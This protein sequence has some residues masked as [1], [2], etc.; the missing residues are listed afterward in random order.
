MLTTLNV[1]HIESLNDVVERITGVKVRERLPDK[2]L[3]TADEIELIDL[4]PEELGKRLREG[5]VYVPEDVQRAV[6]NFF[7]RGNL[8]VL[9]ELAMRMAVER[10]DADL[11]SY[12]RARAIE[13]P[14]PARGRILVCIG[15]DVHAERLVRLGKRTADRRQ[16][17]WTV[18]HVQTRRAEELPGEQR[19]RLQAAFTLAEQLGARAE[20]INGNSIASEALAYAATRNVTEIIVG[21]SR[22]RLVQLRLRPS[23]ASTLIERGSDFEITVASQP[24]DD[25]SAGQRRRSPRR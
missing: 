1:Q 24:Q 18:L 7:T 4:P 6:E 13:G 22:R 16:L 11:Q 25:A 10:V 20:S 21:R 15:A 17:P 8:L 14:W 3:E 9:R 5:K 12:M 2:V 23:L 19:E